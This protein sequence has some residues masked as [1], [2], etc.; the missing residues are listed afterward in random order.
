MTNYTLTDGKGTKVRETTDPNQA[1]VDL[2]IDGM[3]AGSVSDG[4]MIA[5]QNGTSDPKKVE[6]KIHLFNM[7]YLQ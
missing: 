2:D 1:H 5:L 4:D 3:D 6:L 7:G